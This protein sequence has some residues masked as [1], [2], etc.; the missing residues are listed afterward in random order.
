M[1]EV[2]VVVTDS[3]GNSDEQD[4][5]VKVTNVEE[6]G[7]IELSTLQPRVDFPVTATLADA[8]NITAGSVSW[9]WYK[10]AV[11]Q[12]LLATLDRNECGDGNTDNC[13]IKGATSATY[14]PVAD[15]VNDD[16]VAVALYTDGSPNEADAKDF[17]MMVTANQVL[18]DTRNKAPVFPDQDLEMDGRQ[19]AQ[20][21]SVDENTDSDAPIGGPVKATDS[22]TK[23]DGEIED[24][25]LTYTLGGP[26][27]ASFTIDRGT[28]QLTTKVALDKETKDT[29][30]VTVTATDPS[31]ETDTVMVTIKVTNVDE[32]PEIMVGGLAISGMSSVDYAENGTMPVGNYMATGPDA[33]MATWTLS[34]DDASAFSLS[35]DGMLTFRSSP[36]YENPMDADMDNVYMVTIMADDGTYMDT[37][38]VMVM[39]TN[40]DEMGEVTLWA[41]A[42]ALTMA[43]Q[44]GDTITGAVMD[45]DGNPGDMLPIA[46]DT[47]INDVTWQWY[48]T[49][50]PAMMESWMPIT[51][52]TDAAYMV[53]A[54]DTDYYL[55]VMATYTD[56][57]DMAMEDSPATMMVTAMM[58]VPMFDS[59]TATREVA[60]NTEASM[61]IGDPVMGTDADGDTLIYALGGTDAGSFY[62]VPETGQ[63][64]TLAALDYETKATY[65]VMV[66]A[67]DPDSASDMITVTIT[68][69]NVEELGMVT[70]WAGADAL[71]MAPQVGDTI[72]GAVMDP[73]GNPGDMLPIAMDTT[74]NDVTWQWYRTT[75]PAMMESWMP[76]TG[77]TD[78]AYMVTAGDT[79]YYLRVM[80][81]YTDAAGTDMAMEDSPAT[82]MVTA[83][84]TVPMFDSE[85]ATREVAENTEAS[86]DIGA[87]VMGTDADGDTLIYA[88]GGTDA[89]SFYIDP[90]T[91][92]LKT[93]AALDYETKATYSVMVTATDPDS[94][95]DMITVTITVTN[96]DEPGMVTLWAETVALTMAPQVGDTITGA[97]MDPDN[98][99][100]DATVDSWQWSRT[101]D[102]ADMS[103]WMDITGETNA[104]YMVTEGDTGYYLRVMATYT[105]AAG[106][107]MAMEYSMPTMMVTA[108]DETQPADFDPLAKYDADKSGALEKDEVIQAINDY[109][110]GVGADAISKEDVIETIN[111]YLFG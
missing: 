33:D 73:D 76:I 7:T 32:P 52:A 24:E 86:M 11:T 6:L 26:D 105:D 46:M 47:T 22:I 75:T 62:I 8:D 20:E 108:V 15:D 81:T 56:A 106:T 38:D 88:L 94:A 36:D 34:G 50:T 58:T 18:A 45:P 70:L 3:K 30:V 102:T 80:A 13:F 85:T 1:Y 23:N 37:H 78:A 48:R 31:G 35:N 65:S 69:T 87:P 4:V 103:S 100:N 79:D 89:G 41:G 43:P 59:E 109:L 71:T 19:T 12:Q 25:T 90:E 51:G 107:D 10:G 77:A 84:M 42:N 39:V 66:T 5:T 110:F 82:M 72:T 93:L 74:I 95:S 53:T 9:Q 27:A 101:M 98:P 14:T 64:K 21:R 54:G 28:A 29:Y 91:G 97:V 17:A 49:T 92:Q 16:V 99:D 61:D 2:T 55:R 57:A 60:E 96:V 63:L 44:V 67:T 83:M 111:L 40:V 104:A 68:V